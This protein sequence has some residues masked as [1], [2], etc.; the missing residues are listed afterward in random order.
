MGNTLTM[1]ENL[2]IFGKFGWIGNV[3]PP[4]AISKTKINF[5]FSLWEWEKWIDLV[6]CGLC[7]P[8]RIEKKAFVEQMV[9]EQ[10]RKATCGDW[11]GGLFLSSF[12]LGGYGR[13]EARTAPQR[14]ENEDKKNNPIKSTKQEGNQKKWNQTIQWKQVDGMRL[15]KLI[16]WN[17]CGNWIGLIERGPKR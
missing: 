12:P 14:E 7:G 4:L 15:M 5:I 17:Q 13:G 9:D 2:K 16:E 10:W 3:L 8:F 6:C 1:K 11:F